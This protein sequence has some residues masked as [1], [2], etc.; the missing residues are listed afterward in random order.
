M[1][2]DCDTPA[3]GTALAIAAGLPWLPRAPGQFPDWRLDLLGAVGREPALAQ[4][5]AREPGDLGLMLLEMGAYVLD[6]SSFYDGLVANESY[7]RT[8]RLPGAQREHV[9]LLGYLPRPALASSVWL[10]AQVDGP[11]LVTLPAGTAIRSG[12]FDGN[13]PQVFELG[14]DV[15]A[16]P[17]VNL[18]AVDRVRATALPAPLGSLTATAASVRARAG[19]VLVLDMGGTLAAT[20]VAGIA[21]ATQRSGDDVLAIAL[22]APVTPPSG[23]RFDALRVLKAG[24]LCG[25]CKVT[26]QSG[27]PAVVGA[28]ELSLDTRANVRAGDVVAIVDGATL[29][30]CRVTA[31]ADVQYTLLASQTSTITDSSNH[32]TTLASP[33]VLG[34]FTRLSVDA[35]LAAFSGSAQTLALHYAMGDAAT[36]YAPL[37]DTLAQGDPIAVPGL[38]GPPRVPVV[39]LQL[40]DAH[41]QAVVTTGTLDA[42]SRTATTDSAP[43]WGKT[44]WAPVQ[45]A[46]NTMLATRGETV[47][48]EH[49]G[50][51]DATQARQVFTL[52]KAPLTWLPAASSAGRASTLVVH[53]AGIRWRE[54]STFHGVADDQPVFITR[55][56]D[57]GNT[58]VI[59]GGGARLPTGAA[60]VAD[61]RFGAG[62]AVPP[63][64]S[65]KQVTRSVAGLRTVHNALPAFGGADAEGAAELAIRGPRSA[66]LLGRAISL[67][68]FETAAIQQSGV[69]AASATWRWD[70]EGLR[71]AVM[72]RYIGDAQ[73]APTLLATLRALAEDDAP[74]AVRAAIAQSAR[75]DV[76]IDIDA[77]R[78]PTDVVAAVCAALFGAVT[79]PGTGGLLQPENLAPDGVLFESVVVRAIARVPGVAALRSLRLDATPFTDT[80]RAPAAGAYFDFAA[81]GVRVNGQLA[82]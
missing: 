7:L 29:L 79:L 63:A 31:V 17:R 13:P 5:R 8:A 77:D 65:V 71:P 3:C 41:G 56:D 40:E 80:G 26:P 73:L 48:A 44:L 53:V 32:V 30:A 12:S 50:T 46:G 45:L 72:V 68:D 1:S 19:D 28:Q 33:P 78:V 39:A 67:D 51:G 9:A 52:A 54:V 38:V 59:F 55:T 70:A 23:A 16:D 37:Q 15:V 76:D 22:A 49:L 34:T 14:A 43:D 4:W 27:Q 74:I 81:G 11:R 35:S 69:R 36:P 61:Y 75:L 58:Q 64:D 2:C 66:L 10:A 21:P 42:A 57:A 25:A 60:V 20:R 24:A 6:V 62:A 82:S 47:S 18:L